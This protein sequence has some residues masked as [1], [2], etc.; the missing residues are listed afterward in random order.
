MGLIFGLCLYLLRG[1]LLEELYKVCPAEC[2]ALEHAW[3]K[4]CA[5][6]VSRFVS[7]LASQ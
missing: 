5:L 4:L 1:T 2:I 7:Q 6:P 3:F